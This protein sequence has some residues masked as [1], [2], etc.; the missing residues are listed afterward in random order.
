VGIGRGSDHAEGTI[1][2]KSPARTRKET[3]HFIRFLRLQLVIFSRPP[4]L[5]ALGEQPV[6]V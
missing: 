2:N 6:S 5:V 3:T 4:P 1:K